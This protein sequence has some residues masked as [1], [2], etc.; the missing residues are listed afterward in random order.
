MNSINRR[1]WAIDIIF[2]WAIYI[3]FEIFDQANFKRNFSIFALYK[4]V[5]SNRFFVNPFSQIKLKNGENR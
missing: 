3:I 4:Q 2:D 1:L 5:T